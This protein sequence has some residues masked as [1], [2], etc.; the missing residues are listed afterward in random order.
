MSVPARS[1][2]KKT[3]ESPGN[4]DGR[5]TDAISLAPHNPFFTFAA[6]FTVQ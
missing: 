6:W 1:A 4:D 2:G 3:L 5:L